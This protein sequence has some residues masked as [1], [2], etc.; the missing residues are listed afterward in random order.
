MKVMVTVDL[1]GVL[2]DTP[3]KLLSNFEV[4]YNKKNKKYSSEELKDNLKNFNPDIIIAGTEKYNE[5]VLN[6]CPNLKMISRVGIG[7]DSIDLNECKKR[8]IFVANTPDAPSNAV[9]DLIVG[10]IIN[11]LREIQNVDSSIRKGV[12]ER[13][14]GKEICECNIGIIGY[15]RIGRL[16]KK[17][18]EAFNPK[19]ILINDIDE[20]QLKE[21]S[22]EEICTKD[23]IYQNSDI[24]SI[25]IPYNPQN[26]NLIAEKELEKM[27]PNTL[28]LNFSRGGIINEEDLFKWLEKNE[29][30]KCAIDVFI[31]EPYYGELIKLKNSFLT[32]HLGSCS[33]KSRNDMEV[34]AV[35]NVLEFLK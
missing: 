30:A 3:R 29:H 8:G 35:R 5:E 13:Y 17:R 16:V 4:E 18:L 1:F 9:A 6:C 34:G 19:K 24:I 22:P 27:K 12:W 32:P 10:Q 33:K 25:H 28:L 26:Y 21:L 31:E 7:L 15:G 23:K 11:M 14:I 2:D 20:D